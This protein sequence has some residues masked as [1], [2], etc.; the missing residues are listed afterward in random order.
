[1]TY[2][3]IAIP[4]NES[5][6]RQWY[7]WTHK[8][9]SDR[10]KRN[11]ERIPDVV[12][13]VRLRLL[14]KD[15]IGRWFYKHLP[16]ELVDR[17]QAELILGGANVAFIGALNPIEGRRSSPDSLWRVQDLLDFAKFDHE[18]YYYSVQDHTIDTAMVLRLIGYPEGEYS[19]LQSLFR[20]GRLKPSEMTEHECRRA[21]KVGLPPS[22]CPGCEHGV[23]LLNARG[24]SLAADWSDPSLSAAIDRLRWNDTQ[25]K[26]F[27]RGWKRTNLI[28]TTPQYVMRSDP[29]SGVDAGLLKYAKILISNTVNNC[30]KGMQRSDDIRS[31]ILNNGLSPEFSDDET[32]GWET[33]ESDAGFCR[34]VKD[35]QGASRLAHADI[36][37]D[38]HSMIE[39]AG[40][41][42]E[43][44]AV[45]QA[46][47]LGEV[48][49]PTFAESSGLSVAKIQR[50]RTS[51]IQK[52]KTLGSSDSPESLRSSAQ[53]MVRNICSKY[54]CE[55]S[56]LF[57]PQSF[58]PVVRAR[59]DLFSN[60]F[61]AGMS[62]ED[63]AKAFQYP[64][65]RIAAAINRRVI[66]E[67]GRESRVGT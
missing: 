14:A 7:Q 32:M 62:M 56:D 29:K 34:T 42:A 52:L 59:T 38:V 17:T 2:Y 33:D 65:E 22:A 11:R 15:F 64:E 55:E 63:M 45:I 43:E 36:G 25:L 24:L 12:Q 60:L 31:S 39:R 6:L 19:I 1:M 51:A 26:P 58:G 37:R 57:G 9:V 67:M 20:Q 27:L 44:K 66:G 40:L 8:V 41:S 18:R 5:F 48:S 53:P 54:S 47:D 4:S 49:V 23:S 3:P 35:S 50:L 21:G 46:V 30:F 13:D 28:R 16:D 61:D 10:F